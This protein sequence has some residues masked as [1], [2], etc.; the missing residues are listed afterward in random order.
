MTDNKKPYTQSFSQ[1]I[2]MYEYDEKKGEVIKLPQKFDQQA[3]IQS[4]SDCALDKILDKYSEIMPNVD[5]I[6]LFSVDLATLDDTG[7]NDCTVD[8]SLHAY[9]D[10]IS[11]AEDIR[12]QY[13]LPTN[14]SADDVYKQAYELVN[15]TLKKYQKGGTQNETQ[16][17][18]QSEQ[19]QLSPNSNESE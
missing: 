9:G 6:S 8:N 11:K 12:E 15:S 2:D 17:K 13:N 14:L 1:Y 18:S 7:V 5:P 16:N 4:F 19:T 10:Y 3:Y